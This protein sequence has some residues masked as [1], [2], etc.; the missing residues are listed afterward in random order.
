YVLTRQGGGDSG[1]YWALRMPPEALKDLASQPAQDFQHVWR[2]EQR[3]TQRVILRQPAP[4]N[5]ADRGLSET[6][7]LQPLSNSDWQ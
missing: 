3:K 6:V 2:L 4:S 1:D 5:D 7:L